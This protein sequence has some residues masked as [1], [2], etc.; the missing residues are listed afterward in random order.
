MTAWLCCISA[1]D[2]FRKH[3]TRYWQAVFIITIQQL[4]NYDD[5]ALPPCG[6]P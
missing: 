3:L 1:I 2:G 6:V 5:V 4:L